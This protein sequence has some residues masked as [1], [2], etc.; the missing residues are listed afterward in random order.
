MPTSID[1]SDFL[2][3]FDPLVFGRRLRHLRRER[4]LTLQALA[5]R[6]DKHGPY[7]S[8]LE[9]GRRQPTLATMQALA[10]ALHV[11]LAELLADE[12]P[13]RRSWLEVQVAR[14]QREPLYR[15]LD[16]PHLSPT[17]KTPDETLEH[18]VRLYGEL[19]EQSSV[20]AATP[21]EARR[22]NARLR[23]A[24]RKAD[25][26]FPDI[27]R[28]ASVALAAVGYVDGDV[29]SQ[30]HLHDLAAHFGFTL[31]PT[32]DIPSSVRSLT[33]L[34]HQRIYIPQRDQLRTRAARSVVLQTLGH[35]ALGHQE[36]RSFGDFLR[37]RVETNY[38]AGAILMPES[39][40]STY[41]QKAKAARDICVEDLKEVFYVSYEMA[42]HRFTNLATRHLDIPT[43][44][45][46]SDGEGVIWKAFENDGL[47]FPADPDGAIEGNLLCRE[48]GARMVFRSA[49]KFDIHYQ[50]SDTPAGTYWSASHVE[51]DEQPYH[52]ITVGTTFEGARFF[53]GRN[54]TLRTTS[55]CPDGPCCRRPEP[56][57]AARWDGLAWPSARV[58]S[59]V[60]AALPVGT[61]PGVDLQEVYAFL[62]EQRDET[63]RPTRG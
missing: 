13:S 15:S 51:P 4:N 27:E 43:H 24:M 23:M 63:E 62:D 46:R 5:E 53:R 36:P 52:A 17:A 29:I 48:W 30:R 14:I 31:H 33:D 42:A 57:L 61:F 38:F 55:Q 20:R 45:I 1:S 25:N 12:A 56:A 16:L 34:R 50:W 32:R 8:L 39:A 2:P 21:E 40:A 9:N 59:H 49:D 58:R 26:Y 41:L 18:I 19:R 10:V 35:F 37:Q 3:Q 54:A 44:F 60:L 6:V 7:L 47:P 28:A 22:N 11:D